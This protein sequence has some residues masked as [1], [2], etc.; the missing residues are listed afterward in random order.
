MFERAEIKAKSLLFWVHTYRYTDH[1]CDWKFVACTMIKNPDLRSNIFFTF[2]IFSSDRVVL[3]S[4]LNQIK[5]IK[6]I[7][8]E[9]K[10]Y[11]PSIFNSSTEILNEWL[12]G[13]KIFLNTLY[14][15]FI[16]YGRCLEARSPNHILGSSSTFH[17]W[18]ALHSSIKNALS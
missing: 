12:N 14:I 6:S 17:R 1:F 7:G 9:N 16:S 18:A 15:F 5:S 13:I 11:F 3:N 10:S 8:V 4:E 2:Y